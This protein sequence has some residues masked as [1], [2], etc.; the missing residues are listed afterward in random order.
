MKNKT[1]KPL[2]MFQVLFTVQSYYEKHYKLTVT[3]HFND[4]NV[5]IQY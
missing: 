2:A 1:A 5:T 3:L 4:S